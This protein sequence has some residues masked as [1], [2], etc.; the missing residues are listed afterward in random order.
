[1]TERDDELIRDYI[2]GRTSP[3]DLD[4]LNHLL[5]TDPEARA[6]YRALAT[7]DEG[8]R[9]LAEIPAI[10]PL[11]RVQSESVQGTVGECTGY[12]ERSI[13]VIA[14]FLSR[15]LFAAAAGLLIGVFCT[16][17]IWAATGSGRQKIFNL[18]HESFESGN[19]PEVT[20]I[21]IETGMWGGDFTEIVT[22][23]EGVSP[24][25][26]E[27]M[28]KFLRADHKGKKNPVGY[29][30]DL[31]RVIDLRGHESI[32][33]NDDAVVS[34]ESAFCSIP[35]AEPD[36]FV[37]G[38]GIYAL[39]SLP[40]G[41][42]SWKNWPL[43]E[44]RLSEESLATAQR[45]ISLSPSGLEWQKGRAEL[46]L[47]TESRYLLVVIHLSDRS[48]ILPSGEPPAVEFTGQFIDDV[49]ITLKRRSSEF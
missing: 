37:C 45:W 38:L 5:E 49:R 6:R 27:R 42:D 19:P 2:D 21:P 28:L 40:S 1:M 13:P 9:D 18:L 14:A 15:P 3:A 44:T 33:E 20:G 35:F 46:R 11:Y 47:P 17:A 30:G 48:A 36:R 7:L 39:S 23:T 16:S 8:L 10:S 4:K 25:H 34:V 12:S 43:F 29:V 22:A 26:G 32:L 24:R 31:Y 41:N